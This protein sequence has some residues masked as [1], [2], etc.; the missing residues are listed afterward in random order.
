[1]TLL[2][3]D[4]EGTLFKTEIRLA[5][6]GFYST[7]WQAIARQ[8]GPKAENEEIVTHRKWKRKE[9]RGY[10]DWMKDT[11]SIHMKYGLSKPVF[12]RIIASAKYNDG[13]LKTLKRL[14]RNRYEIVLFSGG[15]REL[16]LRVQMALKIRHAFTACEYSFS[17]GGKLENFNLLPCDFKGKLVFVKL[18][19]REYNLR[20]DDWVFVGDGLNDLEVARAA[21]IS[22]GYRPH[23]SLRKVATYSTDDFDRLIPILAKQAR[24]SHRS[25]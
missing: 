10:I 4:V 2:V 15:F 23:P 14:D 8:L 3:L 9:Y 6:T 19:L 1:M 5:G 24:V 22:I 20:S 11:I 21:P 17:R 25:S 16:A 7:I 13:V 18:M 12:D